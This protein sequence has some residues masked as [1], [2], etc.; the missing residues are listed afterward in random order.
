MVRDWF[1]DLRY[2]VDFERDG[3]YCLFNSLD[4]CVGNSR[5]RCG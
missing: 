3:V 5:T 4:P 2:P 1:A